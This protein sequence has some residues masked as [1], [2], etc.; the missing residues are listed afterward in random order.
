MLGY[1]FNTEQEALNAVTQCD[2]HYGYPKQDSMT[3]NWCW[4]SFSEA[5]NFYYITHDESIEV[6]LGAPSEFE[7]TFTEPSN[8]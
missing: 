1:K 5:D 3:T 2:N 6:V 7:V 4:Y 8:N